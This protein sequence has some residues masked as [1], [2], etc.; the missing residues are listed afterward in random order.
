MKGLTYHV[1]CEDLASHGWV[2]AAIDPPYNAKGVRLL[3][4]RVLGNLKPAERG[5]GQPKNREDGERFY[6]ER[7]VH[8]ARDIKFV[9]DQLATLDA[10]D[11]PFAKRL[12]LARGV[13]VFGHSRGGQ[14]AGTVRLI[15]ERVKGAINIDGTAGDRPVLP[16]PDKTDCGSQPFLWIQKSLPKPPTEEQLKRAKRTRAE[17]DAEVARILKSW[18]DKLSTI[19]GGALHVY[20]DRPEVD[21]IDFSDERFWDGSMTDENREGRQQTI[22]LSRAWL[23]AFFDGTIR[24]Q[25]GDL[26]TLSEKSE[27]NVTVQVF[28]KM[29]P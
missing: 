4:G 15:D 12:D 27:P 23:R 7:I 20:I 1:Y 3:D 26:K 29:W 11:G 28:G 16:A 18:S 24:G 21:H 13:G 8:W 10:G 17:Y 14:A 9:I 2:V 19:S 25:W 5:W 22:S 6:I